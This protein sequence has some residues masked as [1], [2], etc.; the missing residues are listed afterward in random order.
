MVNL[1][2]ALPRAGAVVFLL[3]VLEGDVLLAQVGV[4]PGADAVGVNG[5]LGKVAIDVTWHL[6]AHLVGV[7]VYD[8]SKLATDLLIP[9]IFI[10]LWID[11][12]IENVPIGP[13]K[14]GSKSTNIVLLLGLLVPHMV[15]LYCDPIML[16]SAIKN[17]DGLHH[18]LVSIRQLQDVFWLQLIEATLVSFNR[19]LELAD[20]SWH[21]LHAELN[22][23][24]Y[25]RVLAQEVVEEGLPNFDKRCFLDFV[26]GEEAFFVVDW[27]F[28]SCLVYL[29]LGFGS[30]V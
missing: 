28:F 17:L 26:L 1:D 19:E 10:I 20:E 15:T 8:A 11:S 30:R 14:V 13:S 21:R 16:G 2:A 29:D 6:L 12:L 7:T 4:W 27:L 22:L 25:W 18:Q 23:N 9:T 24:F 5:D 3:L